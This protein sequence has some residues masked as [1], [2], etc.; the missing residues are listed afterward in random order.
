[1]AYCRLSYSYIGR[2]YKTSKKGVP[3]IAIGDSMNNY[4]TAIIVGYITQEIRNR[5]ELQCKNVG[6]D[7]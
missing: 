5:I 3:G 1:M 2:D 6:N 4:L 7:E